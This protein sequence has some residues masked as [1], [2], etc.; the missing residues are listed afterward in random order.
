MKMTKKVKS[1]NPQGKGLCPVI[2]R[3]TDLQQHV[4]APPKP[5]TRIASELFTSLFILESRIRFKPVLDR[6]Y[7]LYR[8]GDD[9]HLSLIGPTEWHPSLSG[10]YIGE[11]RLHPDLT[12]SLALSEETQNNRLL[13]EEI[14]FRRQ[15][16]DQ[17]LQSAEKLNDALPVF[18]ND[19]SYH[20]RV[21]AS[22]LA[23]S[24]ASSMRQTDILG[25]SFAQALNLECGMITLS[26]NDD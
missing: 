23:F 12:W 20:S 25:L 6:K 15:A 26:Q 7:W 2:D 16:F 17:K 19:F 9:Y 11:C 14:Q 3:L 21:L 10:H 4:N 18:V 22:A 1:P 5:I 24:L 13:M 8:K